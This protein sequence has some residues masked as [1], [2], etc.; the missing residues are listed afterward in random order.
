MN[1]GQPIHYHSQTGT[2]S[3]IDLTLCSSDCYLDFE[4]SVGNSLFGSD[5]YPV[6]LKVIEQQEDITF[7]PT[8]DTERAH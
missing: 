5:N 3:V 6:E 2:S 8:F 4:Y 7:L 1:N